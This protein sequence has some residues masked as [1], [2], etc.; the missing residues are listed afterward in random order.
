MESEEKTDPFGHKI[1]HDSPDIP[2]PGPTIFF[3]DR[4][5]H[6]PFDVQG[7]DGTGHERCRS[8]SKG[9]IAATEIYHVTHSPIEA[10]ST[11]DLVEIEKIRPNLFFGHATVTNFHSVDLLSI[12]SRMIVKP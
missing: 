6:L 5:H 1:T 7:I 4:F 11:Q 2:Y 12:K 8:Q 3:L 10:E 9:P